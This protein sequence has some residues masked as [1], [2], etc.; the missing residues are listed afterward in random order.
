[1][2]KTK[3]FPAS[4]QPTH[5]GIYDVRDSSISCKCCHTW[6][7]WDGRQFV[8][9]GTVSGILGVYQVVEGVKQWRGLAEEAK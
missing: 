9:Y 1:M 4:I 2:R 3:W 7:H 6:A 5:S 8:R